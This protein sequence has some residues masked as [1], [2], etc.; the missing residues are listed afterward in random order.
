MWFGGIAAYRAA[1]RLPPPPL[2]QSAFYTVKRAEKQ[3]EPQSGSRCLIGPQLMWV[4]LVMHSAPPSVLDR[5]GGSAESDGNHRLAMLIPSGENGV[6]VQSAY[7]KCCRSL[8]LEINRKDQSK[9]G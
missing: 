9:G 6:F 2:A 5:T 4:L 7:F 3:K 1:I 8:P